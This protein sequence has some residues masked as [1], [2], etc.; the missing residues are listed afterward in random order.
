MRMKERDAIAWGWEVAITAFQKGITYIGHGLNKERMAADQQKRLC[1]L[2][3][4]E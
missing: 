3:N 4:R 2:P 1:R